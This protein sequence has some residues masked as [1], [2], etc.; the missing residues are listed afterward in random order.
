MQ[1]QFKYLDILTKIP[2][3]CQGSNTEILTVIFGFNLKY[4]YMISQDDLK[5][6]V[7]ISK[8]SKIGAIRL[9]KL[10]NFFH[11]MKEAW[12]ASFSELRQAG[13]DENIV[14]DFLAQKTTINPDTEWEK[15]VKE[16]ITVL[17]INDSIYPKLLKEIWNPPAILYVKGTLPADDEFNLAVV[18]TRKISTYGRQL[19]SL[20]TGEL[21]QSGFNIVSG[22]ALGVDALAHQ[23]TV[24]LGG[25]T[26]A[27]L[28]SGIDN[29]SVYPAGNRFLASE[30]VKTGGAIISEFPLGTV[31]MPG[32]F[33]LRNR[34]VSGLSLGTL[35]IEAAEESGALI[36]AQCAL[37]QNRE[38]FA[39]PGSIFNPTSAGPNKL[40]KM[41]AKAVTAVN[42]ILETL[43]LAQAADFTKNKK[44]LPASPEEEKILIN[45][46]QE[47]TH[48]DKLI[49]TSGLD[50]A[51][52]GAILTLMEM[53]G[54]VRNL[55]GMNYV[56]G[57]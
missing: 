13:L 44:L 46:S 14:H 20:L 11:S 45:L 50:A 30:I 57:K 10:F 56:I 29:E 3:F 1:T 27:V 36:T 19:A 16:N 34:I 49:A 21:V 12:Q 24:R 4:F 51:K 37:E 41:G 15:L 32:N 5:Y 28:G 26:I 54:M 47:P 6:W 53:K 43:N 35:V 17:T 40:I 42:D 7:A 23:T 2:L 25:K 52:V 55:G 8:F 31:A 33:P 18:G 38:V 9:V 39:V 22:L 48:V